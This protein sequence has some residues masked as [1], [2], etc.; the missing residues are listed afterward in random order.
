MRAVSA[1]A[2]LAIAVGVHADTINS[3]ASIGTLDTFTDSGCR[4]GLK[5]TDLPDSNAAGHLGS[6]ITSVMAKLSKCQSKSSYCHYTLILPPPTTCF[7]VIVG[8]KDGGPSR[9]ILPGDSTCYVVTAT[10]KIWEVSCN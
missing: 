1:V 8:D 2:A 6:E 7:L 4:E 9:V 5:S 3:E 10:P